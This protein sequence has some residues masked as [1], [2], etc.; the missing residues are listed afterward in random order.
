MTELAFIESFLHANTAYA[1]EKF[2]GRAGVTVAEKRDANDLLTEVDLTLQKRAV[3][4]LRE[5]FPGDRIV[6]EEGEYAE[7]PTHTPPRAWVM[8]PLDGTNNFV[9]GLFPVFGISLA[10]AVEGA[11]VAGG[12]ALPGEHT[13]LTARRGAGAAMDGARLQV[14]Q[15]QSVADARID[16]DFSGRHDREALLGRASELFRQAG[17]VRCHGSAVASICQIATSDCDAY[18]HMSLHPWDYAA[19]QLIV[20]EAGGMA[21]RLDGSPLELFDGK[22]GVLISNGAIHEELLAL[23]KG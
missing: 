6:A 20:E 14:S 9:R 10:F 4:A 5:Q 13:I 8:D 7:I 3:E 21:S 18:V 15:V 19:A 23:L 16:F 12:V 17:Q 1:L 11:A 2:R 22:Q